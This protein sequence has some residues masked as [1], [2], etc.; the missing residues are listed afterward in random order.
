[1]K[2]RTLIISLIILLVGY[3]TIFVLSDRSNNTNTAK[4]TTQQE[5]KYMLKEFNGML[6]LFENDLSQPKEIYNISISSFPEEDVVK[7][8]KGIVVNGADELNRLLEDYTS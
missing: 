4:I 7:L 1:M 8:K 3:L 2:K 5:N 6:A